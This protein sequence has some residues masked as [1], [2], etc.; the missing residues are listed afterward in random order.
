MIIVGM[1]YRWLGCHAK[2]ETR[3]ASEQ[4]PQIEKER[5]DEQHA[6]WDYY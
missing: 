6:N 4:G 1:R 5:K 3:G 2:K